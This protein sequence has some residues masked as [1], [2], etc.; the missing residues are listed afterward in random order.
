M[1][2]EFIE[3]VRE[4]VR[5]AEA[6]FD[7]DLGTVNV[8]FKLKGRVAGEAQRLGSVSYLRFNHDAVEDY[9]DH[10]VES[11]ILHEVAHLVGDAAQSATT[12]PW[13]RRISGHNVY[14]M[15]AAIALGDNDCS[16]THDLPLASAKQ[17]NQYLYV[18]SY[19]CELKVSTVVHNRIQQGRPYTS[20][21]TGRAIRPEHCKGPVRWADV[22]FTL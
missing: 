6:L 2:D 1:H 12:H 17:M 4:C 9:W 15:R 16:R 8:S 5:R 20:R 21:S 10:M 7:V 14:W 18:D 11:T 3:K 22:K 13:A 19:G